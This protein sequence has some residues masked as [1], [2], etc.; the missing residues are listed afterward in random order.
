MYSGVGT[1]RVRRGLIH[2]HGTLLPND[3]RS[4]TH[5]DDDDDDGV[6]VRGR[7]RLTDGVKVKLTESG[8]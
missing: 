1:M 6:D 8:E 2:D 5:D 7:W 4:D 3:C